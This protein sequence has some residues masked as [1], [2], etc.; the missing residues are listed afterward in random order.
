MNLN[1]RTSETGVLWQTLKVYMYCI[2]FGL[3]SGGSRGDVLPTRRVCRYFSEP[4]HRAVLFPTLVATCHGH[5]G[6]A[7]VAGN[8]LAMELLAEFLE[9]NLRASWQ[10]D[11]TPAAGAA[12]GAATGAAAGAGAGAGVA[13][14]HPVS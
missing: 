11:E 10:T 9:E 12:A 7:A 1:L 2:R 8:D 5:L 13:A 4:R 6:N 3:L 14:A